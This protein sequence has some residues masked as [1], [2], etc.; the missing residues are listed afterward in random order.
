MSFVVTGAAGF[1][2]SHLVEALASAGHD[3]IGIDRRAGIPAAARH[4]ILV[5]L[6]FESPD[7]R[8]ALATADAVWHLAACP[9]V[10]TTGPDIEARRHRDNVV[11]GANVLAAV[12]PAVRVVVVSSSSVYGGALHN[13]VLSP[14]RE[15]DPL[16]PVGGYARSKLALEEL[17][18][19]R[20]ASGGAVTIVRPF[21]V[22][23]ERQRPDMA[24]ARWIRAASEGRP[25]TILGSPG[26]TRDVTDVADVVTGL[27]RIVERD[28]DGT[29]NLGA[30][31]PRS[32]IELAGAVCDVLEVACRFDVKPAGPEEVVATWACLD[33]A[34]EV[35]GYDPRTDLTAIVRRQA[36]ALQPA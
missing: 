6:A 24:I 33:R 11:A 19:G 4:E 7:V 32:L 27:I 35:L 18:R 3:V 8:D 14:S 5:D 31:S 23:G 12:Q 15:E 34:R 26:R 16:S 17:A 30:G 2:G 20:A 22:A 1:I 25:L 29:F 10:R 13:G 21:T 36:A 9:G 28:A